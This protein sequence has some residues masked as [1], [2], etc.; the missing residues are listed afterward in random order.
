MLTK[1]HSLKISFYLRGNKD[2]KQAIYLRVSINNQRFAF[3]TNIS[4]L[5]EEWDPIDQRIKSKNKLASTLNHQLNS[6]QNQIQNEY[7]NST[8]QND[9]VDIAFF[10]NILFPQKKIITPKNDE[11]PLLVELIKKFNINIDYRLKVKTIT[12]STYR[13]HKFLSKT[14]LKYLNLYYTPN[15]LKLNDL[16]KNFLIK[17]ELYLIEL[18]SYKNNYIFKIVKFFNYM[19]N[20]FHELEWT[21]NKLKF[22]F[23]SRYKNPKREILTLDEVKKIENLTELPQSLAD[24]RNCALIQCY[25]GLAYSDLKSLNRSHIKQILGRTWIVIPRQ[26]TEVI[27]RIVVIEKA[28]RILK[29]YLEKKNQSNSL[30]P[31][32]SNCKYNNSLK[33]IQKFCNIET[34]ISSHILRHTFS[35]TIALSLGL[36]METLSKVLGHT[37]LKTTAI[38]GK[39]IDQ[40]ILEEFTIMEQNLN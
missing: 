31:I 25:T 19:L 26:K 37:S 21:T 35:T 22:N 24:V 30:L 6:Y 1:H 9:L 3:S 33:E 15:S 17:F 34:E 11:N 36:S 40:K 7:Y 16:D 18:N 20:Y 10:K 27:S 12:Y 23:K 28:E 38:Y 14:Y 4:I 29:N 32:K 39:V 8:K 2:E 5:K 13:N